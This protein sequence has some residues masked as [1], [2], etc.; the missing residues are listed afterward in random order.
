[1]NVSIVVPAYNEEKLLPRTLAAI[2][3][4]ETAF[5]RRNWSV[6]VV[7][8]DNNSTDRT[9]EIARKEGATVVF[10]PVNQIGRARN[11]GAKAAQGDWII[12]IDA[13]SVPDENLFEETARAMES[14]KYLAGGATVRLDQDL[15]AMRLIAGLWNFLSR[16]FRLA[17]GSYIFCE[18]ELFRASGG[19]NEK[20]YAS[21]ELD[22]F[23]RLKRLSR[24]RGKSTLIL[25][26]QSLL[27]SAR[28]AHLY[29]PREHGLFLLRTVFSGGRNLKD[30]ASCAPWY[31]GRR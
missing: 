23:R 12:F 13:D 29:S 11:T 27:T 1:M 15:P 4:A 7:V 26:K 2:R 3:A 21:E 24:R 9:S 19:F 5:L 20:L 18:T 16:T 10:E 25:T 28:K 30:R 6:E 31:D 22:F 8:C 14:G 17:A